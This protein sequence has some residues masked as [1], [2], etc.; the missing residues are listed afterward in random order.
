MEDDKRFIKIKLDDAIIK[1]TDEDGDEKLRLCMQVSGHDVLVRF[2][3]FGDWDFYVRDLAALMLLLSKSANDIELDV[4]LIPDKYF[5]QWAFVVSEVLKFKECRKL[6]EKI[7][8]DYL[9]PE[10][11]GLKDTDHKVWLSKHLRLFHLYA[12]FQSILHIEDWLKKKAIQ[13]IQTTFQNLIQPSTKAMSAK[14]S[15]SPQTNSEAGQP[16]EFV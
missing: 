1:A 6:V 13:E 3:C 10:V 4:D 11:Q 15:T 14:S 2:P 5:P 8:F 9:S 12:M 7:F 16:Y